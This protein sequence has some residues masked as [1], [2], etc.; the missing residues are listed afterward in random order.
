MVQI[1][2]SPVAPFRQ[3]GTIRELV[4][5]GDYSPEEI[6]DKYIRNRKGSR[7]LQWGIKL[8]FHVS[9]TGLVAFTY[10]LFDKSSVS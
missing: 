10:R 8:G 9:L 1:D 5:E 6:F 7:W 4:F 2:L 3:N